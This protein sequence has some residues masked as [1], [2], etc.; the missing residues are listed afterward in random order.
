[1]RGSREEGEVLPWWPGREEDLVEPGISPGLGSWG[2]V[3]I[4]MHY[5]AYTMHEAPCPMHHPPLVDHHAPYLWPVHQIL[6]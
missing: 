6:L 4:T 1:M 2:A 3:R 5:P